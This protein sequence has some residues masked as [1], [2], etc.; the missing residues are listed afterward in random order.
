MIAGAM[1]R[2]PGFD[3]QLSGPE[4]EENIRRESR[5]ARTGKKRTDAG[6][7]SLPQEVREQG[8]GSRKLSDEACDRRDVV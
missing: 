7:R 5:N 8:E 6:S 2:R 1:R 4:R 3:S